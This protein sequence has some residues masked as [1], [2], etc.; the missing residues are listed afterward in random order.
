[1]VF[2]SYNYS[3]AVPWKELHLPKV[4]QRHDVVRAVILAGTN[5]PNLLE[6]FDR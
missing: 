6:L 3:A 2:L 4:M 1:M 5:S